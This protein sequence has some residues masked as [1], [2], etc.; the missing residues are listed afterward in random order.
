MG[1]TGGAEAE[2]RGA[3]RRTERPQASPKPNNKSRFVQAPALA[4]AY[5]IAIEQQRLFCST[6]GGSRAVSKGHSRGRRRGHLAADRERTPAG[7]RDR[8]AACAPAFRAAL[9]VQGLIGA[10]DLLKIA[11]IRKV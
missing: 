7:R 5:R 4:G 6:L 11:G 9:S 8:S 3:R 1:R 10:D 2:R